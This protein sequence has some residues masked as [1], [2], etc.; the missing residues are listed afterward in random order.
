MLLNGLDNFV[1]LFLG[2]RMGH[3][4]AAKGSKRAFS[5]KSVYNVTNVMYPMMR[6]LVRLYLT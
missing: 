4:R 6:N 1:V 5:Q 3:F 2:G